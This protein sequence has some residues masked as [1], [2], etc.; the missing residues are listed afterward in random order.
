MSARDHHVNIVGSRLDRTANLRYALN[1][2]REPSRK[3]S[4]DSGHAYAAALKRSHRRFHKRVIHA[5]RGDLDVQL[6]NSQ[7]LDQIVLDGM[8]GLGTQAAHALLGV[9]AREGGQV[10]TGN[11]AEQPCR[12][13]V[14]FYRAAGDVALRPAFDRTSVDANL[15]QPIKIQRDAAVRDQRPAGKRGDG[16]NTTAQVACHSM[17]RFVLVRHSGDCH[18]TALPHVGASASLVRKLSRTAG[19]GALGCPPE[20]SSAMGLRQR[21]SSFDRTTE[22]GSPPAAVALPKAH[23]RGARAYIRLLFG[24]LFGLDFISV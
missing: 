20:K 6:F 14:F 16:V 1:Q 19:T 12:L 2:W 4:G 10:H 15:L 13:P 24:L 9:I 22:G 17:T 23:E 5:N 3:S 7:A 21:P 11:G 8:P 18:C